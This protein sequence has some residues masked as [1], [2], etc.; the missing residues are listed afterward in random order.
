[1]RSLVTPSLVVAL[2][3]A[4]ASA[5]DKP[6]ADTPGEAADE[7]LAGR[8][9]AL[10]APRLMGRVLTGTCTAS[11]PDTTAWPGARTRSRR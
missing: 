8:L 9:A 4:G 7:V 10:G 3:A 5:D 1:M 6:E 2:I 11:S